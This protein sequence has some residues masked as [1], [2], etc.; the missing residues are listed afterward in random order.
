MIRV[1]IAGCS[2]TVGNVAISGETFMTG[3]TSRLVVTGTKLELSVHHSG[4][5]LLVFGPDAPKGQQPQMP[6]GT[7]PQANFVDAI[8]GKAAPLCPA[9][10]G[11]TL[12]KFMDAVYASAEEGR[13]VEIPA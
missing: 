4:Q 6:A 3:M 11:L 5:D 12:A 13:P 7:T 9:E 10:Y 1:G 2:N 8:L